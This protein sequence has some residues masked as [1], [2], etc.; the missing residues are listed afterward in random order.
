M[1]TKDCEDLFNKYAKSS[2]GD[3]VSMNEE[4]FATAMQDIADKCYHDI[5][6]N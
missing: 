6:S 4:Q 1:E 5:I 3:T 2:W